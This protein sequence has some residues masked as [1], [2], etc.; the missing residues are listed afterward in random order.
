MSAELVLFDID[1]TILRSEGA[2]IAAMVD[3]GRSLFGPRLSAEGIPIAGR[4]DP[5]IMAEILARA[6][7]EVTREHLGAFRA[8]YT[9]ELERRLGLAETRVRIM[10]GVHALIAALADHAPASLG[11]LTGNFEETGCMKL[12]AGGVDPAPFIFNAWGDD[13]PSSP[14]TRNDLPRMSMNRYQD[15]RGRSL[16]P[17]R[18]VVIGDTP[19]DVACARAHGC[20][21]L[22]VGTGAF[23][24]EALAAAGATLAVPDLS[25]T[26]AVVRWL[27]D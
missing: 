14:P 20:R 10:P 16:D 11:L 19:H 27:L 25:D 8:A 26:V 9:R 15:A 6:G 5:L 2:G 13:S 18:V 23:A 4:L 3:A 17:A 24:P 1:G 22:G 12:R 21:S 7:V